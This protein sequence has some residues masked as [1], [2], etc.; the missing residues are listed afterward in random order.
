MLALIEE[1]GL[2]LGCNVPYDKRGDIAVKEVLLL[3]ALWRKIEY[4]SR[5]GSHIKDGTLD[6]A[7]AICR[8]LTEGRRIAPDELQRLQRYVEAYK[9]L[10]EVL[11]I[12]AKMQEQCTKEP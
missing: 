5:P 11:T 10:R 8:N 2:K 7:L 9:D 3:R 6:E 12:L 1:L 4:E